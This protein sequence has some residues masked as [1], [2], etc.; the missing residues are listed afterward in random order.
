[1]WKPMIAPSLLPVVVPADA[2]VPFATMGCCCCSS[3]SWGS[4][5]PISS[6]CRKTSPSRWADWHRLAKDPVLLVIDDD[7]DDDDASVGFDATLPLLRLLLV[8]DAMM[9]RASFTPTAPRSQDSSGAGSS[10]PGWGS[11]AARG[12]P[13]MP[14]WA[15]LHTRANFDFQQVLRFD[16][17]SM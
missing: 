16:S 11:G 4:L 7:D 12:R 5:R 14:W 1:M 3:G 6:R 10:S 8:D 15:R 2:T 13:R 9:N 17:P